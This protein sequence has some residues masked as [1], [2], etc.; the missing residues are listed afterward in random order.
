MAFALGPAAAE[1]GYGLVQFETIGSTSAEALSRAR[2][3]DAGP[4]WC[5]S[6]HQ[7]QGR[8]RRGRPWETAAGN[9]ASSLLLTTEVSG[10]VAA[11]LGFVAGLALS[12]ALLRVVPHLTVRTGLDGASG[13]DGSRFELKWP[14]D[15]VAGGAK[16]AGILLESEGVQGGRTAIVVGIGVNVVSA[17]ADVPYAAASLNELGGATT[18][19]ALFAALSDSWVSRY[20]EWDGGR[21]LDS[22]RNAWLSRAAGLG[23]PVAV[24]MGSNVIRGTFRTLDSD[25]CLIVRGQDG[26]DVRIAAGEVHFGTV[27]SA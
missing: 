10:A 1:A 3:G 13:R 23:G 7:T 2:A 21:G 8:G 18:A 22:I 17:P 26:R 4:S 24:K 20:L 19:E 15:V 11:T 16:I 6:S 5:V 27:A 25:G 12:D 9:L 14:N